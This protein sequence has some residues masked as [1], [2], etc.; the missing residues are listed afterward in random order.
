VFERDMLLAG[1][2]RAQAQS[3]GL[4]VYEVDGSRS[5]QE[6]AT[7]IEH[8]FEPFLHRWR[9]AHQRSSPDALAARRG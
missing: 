9:E 7:L 4:T 2:L 3:R 1:Q 6:M 5:D 8:H